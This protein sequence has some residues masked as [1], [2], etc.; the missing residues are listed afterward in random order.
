MSCEWRV[1]GRREF[2]IQNSEDRRQKRRRKQNT[3]K[4]VEQKIAKEA[5][6]KRNAWV[7]NP[8]LRTPRFYIGG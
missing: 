8:P 6:K 4:Y 1:V 2:R 3:E 5:K 7:E